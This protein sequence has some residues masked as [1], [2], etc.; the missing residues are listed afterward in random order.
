MGVRAEE[1]SLTQGIGMARG[2]VERTELIGAEA[3]LEVA[4]GDERIT[5][6]GAVAGAPEPGTEVGLDFDLSRVR[7]FHG[8]TGHAIDLQVDLQD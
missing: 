3:L 5:V 2:R 4:V 7:L 6:R 1:V 8:K